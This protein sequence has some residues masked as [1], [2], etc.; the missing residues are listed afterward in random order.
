MAKK[1]TSAKAK[2][3]LHDKSVH[4]KPLTDKQRKFFGAVASG[5]IPYAENGIEGTMGGLTDIGFDYNG[6]WG[7]TMQMGG[8]LPGAT[9]MMYARVG[10]PSN[11]PY[12]KKTK[13]SAQNG[14]E[15]KYYQEG[16]DFKPKTISQDGSKTKKARQPKRVVVFAEAPE[17]EESKA[18]IKESQNVKSFYK[19]VSPNTKV[20]I[21]PIYETGDLKTKQKIQNILSGLTPD[22]DVMVFGHHGEKYAGIPTPQ[23][24]SL[25]GDSNYGN[26]Y[27]GSCQSEDVAAGPWRGVRNLIYRPYSPWEGFNPTSGNV[28]DAM[29]SRGATPP[30]PKY[31]Y[32]PFREEFA[33]E[34]EFLKAQADYNKATEEYNKLAKRRVHKPT[35]DFDYKVKP[36]LPQ[37]ERPGPFSP[38]PLN[39]FEYFQ[40]QTGLPM[41]LAPPAK[42]K[43]ED[44]GWLSKYDDGGIIEDPMGQWAHPGEITRIPS[45]EI[46]MQGVPYPVMGIS[47]TGDTQMMQPGQDYTFDGSSVTEIPMMQNGGLMSYREPM[48]RAKD[49]FMEKQLSKFG[50]PRFVNRTLE[51]AEKEGY[52][53]GEDSEGPLDAIRHAAMS[54]SVARNLKVPKVVGKYAPAL[55]DAIRMGAANLMG[56][57]YELYNFNPEGFWMDIKN[58]YIGS[59]VG[60]MKNLTDEQRAKRIAS[61]LKSDKLSVNNPNKKKKE[62]GGWLSK[63]E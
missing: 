34:K 48:L 38:S 63:Y 18:F 27:L 25:L 24:A 47:D 14:E 10:A 59:D 1:L 42:S 40:R 39:P 35:E 30:P 29:F 50:D 21:L 28:I 41:S 16:L 51:I 12:A 2:K 52:N 44:G 36:N 43:K 20:E 54:A 32:V 17:G 11:G 60:V 58:N 62:N 53:Y 26:C 31:A 19:R 4:G 7:G 37:W 8:S 13:P 5:L 61:M 6:A 3:I 56:L 23:W 49:R 46:T 15:M 45:N 57:G 33:T 55:D 9:G 22:D